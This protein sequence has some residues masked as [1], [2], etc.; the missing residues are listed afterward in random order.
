[1]R[2]H[3]AQVSGARDRSPVELAQRRRLSASWGAAIMRFLGLVAQ[4]EDTP[5]V[6]THWLGLV[7]ANATEGK[8][9]HG[10]RLAAVVLAHDV[11]AVLTLN[12]WHFTRFPRIKTLHH[13]DV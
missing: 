9:A 10:A 4:L 13:L 5:T 2:A 6:F 7:T 11:N 12:D 1:M 8:R 3:R